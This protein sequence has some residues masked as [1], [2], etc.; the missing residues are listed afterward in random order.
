MK[1]FLCWD[2]QKAFPYGGAADILPGPAAVLTGDTL[3]APPSGPEFSQQAFAYD[4]LRPAW[5]YGDMAIAPL[6]HFLPFFFPSSVSFWRQVLV[7][8]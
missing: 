7:Q 4:G 3:V 6:A 2:S 5:R 1:S 8:R